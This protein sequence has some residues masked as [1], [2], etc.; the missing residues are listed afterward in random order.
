MGYPKSQNSALC[1][2]GMLIVCCSSL[3]KAVGSISIASV[4]MNSKRIV[5]KIPIAERKLLT[6]IL[7]CYFNS[8]SVEHDNTMRSRSH[9]FCRFRLTHWNQSQDLLCFFLD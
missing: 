3:P 5:D 7:S 6:G 9:C 8:K 2:V 1:S 4:Y